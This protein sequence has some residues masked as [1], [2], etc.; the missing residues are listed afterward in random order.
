MSARKLSVGGNPGSIPGVSTKPKKT[1]PQSPQTL[2]GREAERS[3]PP[4]EYLAAIGAKG[5]K[6][7]R[8]KLSKKEARRIALIGWDKREAAAWF[9]EGMGR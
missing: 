1:G 2:A 4:T 3:A 5:G 6:K 7:S 9:R 8:R